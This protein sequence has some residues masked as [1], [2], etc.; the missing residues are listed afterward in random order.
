MRT[1]W[2]VFG[3]IA[4]ILNTL[5]GLSFALDGNLLGT[6]LQIGVL[7]VVAA[8]LDRDITDARSPKP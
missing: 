6:L 4:F 1:F 2:I 5:A 8:W 7:F 3:I